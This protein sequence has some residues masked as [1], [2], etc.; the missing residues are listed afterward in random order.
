MTTDCTWGTLTTMA[1][2][3]DQLQLD[4]GPKYLKG[5]TN[6]EFL[7]SFYARA[8]AAGKAAGEREAEARLRLELAQLDAQTP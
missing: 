5:K 4:L 7:A 3:L 6:R 8:Y 1:R 2:N